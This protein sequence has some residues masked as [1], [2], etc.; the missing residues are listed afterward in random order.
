MRIDAPSGHRRDTRDGPNTVLTYVPI[1]II[2][3]SLVA[4][5]VVPFLGRRPGSRR[6]A[7]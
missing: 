6:D 4:L 2:V 1:G 3:L 5:V 7:A